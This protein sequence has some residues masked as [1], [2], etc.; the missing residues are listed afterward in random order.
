MANLLS[1][2]GYHIK[3]LPSGGHFFT[4]KNAHQIQA[5]AHKHNR[6]VTTEQM[7]LISIKGDEPVCEYIHKVIIL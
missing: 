3:N 6:K 5:I 2:E 7:L 1:T 4:P